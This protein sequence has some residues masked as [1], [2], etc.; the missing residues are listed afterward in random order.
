MFFID[1][2]DVDI[3]VFIKFKGDTST[4]GKVKIVNDI[5]QCHRPKVS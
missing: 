2:L 5:Q 4:P 3:N 1:N